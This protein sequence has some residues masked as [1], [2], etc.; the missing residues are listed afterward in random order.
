M[1]C[2]YDIHRIKSVVLVAY[3]PRMIDID[4]IRSVI[5]VVYLVCVI[6][7]LPR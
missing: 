6:I 7:T 5:I 4:R 2:D 3:L 1:L